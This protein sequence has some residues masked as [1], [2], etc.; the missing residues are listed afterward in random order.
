MPIIDS[1][2][3]YKPSWLYRLGH[4]NT[5]MPNL[6]RRHAKPFNNRYRLKLPDSD[7][8]DIDF[9]DQR[10][11]ENLLLLHGLEGSADAQYVKGMA[12]AFLAEGWNVFA[13]NYRGCS[14]EPNR[15]LRAYHS[16]AT[17]DIQ[18]VINWI[19][20]IKPNEKIHLIGFSLGGNLTLKY[21]G[22][23][24]SSAQ[25]YITK[26]VAISAP[27]ALF[28]AVGAIER[29]QNVLYNAR[30]LR[31]LRKKVQEKSK[32]FR[33]AGMDPGFVRNIKRMRG[34]DAWYTAPVH[35]FENEEDYYHKA[36]S[37]YL[38]NEIKVPTLMV[39][40]KDDSFLSPQ[41]YPYQIARQHDQL[42]LETPDFGGHVGFVQEGLQ[43][44][45]WVEA[46]CLDF[47]IGAENID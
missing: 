21:L 8:I 16:G 31:R 47:F 6:F 5:V 23:K 39:S 4:V 28:E 29:P 7:F 27:T 32:L 33:E 41:C 26:A 44:L 34:F 1:K 30:F 15:L 10:G 19:N 12:S 18:P 25:S 38:L 36:S 40:A 17:E 11:K 43:G 45:N 46:R 24:G 22:E 13:M 20:S 35:G 14:G 42:Y 2:K 3:E 37:L 9:N